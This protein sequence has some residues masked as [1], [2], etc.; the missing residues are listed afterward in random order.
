MIKS[1]VTGQAPITLD[2]EYPKEKPKQTKGGTRMKKIYTMAPHD[3][4]THM[5]RV[6]QAPLQLVRSK[7]DTKQKSPRLQY[8]R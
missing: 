8:V 5:L 3:A 2:Q 4:G 7:L 6:G 1:V